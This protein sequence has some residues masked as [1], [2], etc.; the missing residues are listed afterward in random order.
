MEKG[1]RVKIENSP[2]ESMNSVW[3]V[4]NITEGQYHM[5]KVGKNGKLLKVRPENM[6]NPT[7]AQWGRFK[8]YVK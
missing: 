2:V 1:S 5:A 7:F 3:E 6:L 4:Y 8:K